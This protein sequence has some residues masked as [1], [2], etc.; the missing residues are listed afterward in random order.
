LKGVGHDSIQSVIPDTWEI[1]ADVGGL[2]VSG[3]PWAK[4]SK[5]DFK[6]EKERKNIIQKKSTENTT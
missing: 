3:Q 1:E 5:T 4:V 6:K 2:Q